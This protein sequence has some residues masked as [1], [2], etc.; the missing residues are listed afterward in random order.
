E[1]AFTQISTDWHARLTDA[2]RSSVT[3][4]FGVGPDVHI[5]PRRT[6]PTTTSGKVRRQEA[7]RMFLAEAIQRTP[8]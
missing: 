7:K 1:A 4:E 6:I 3:S 8:A 2:V 5:C